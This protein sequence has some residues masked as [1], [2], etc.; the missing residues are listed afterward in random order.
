M[1]DQDAVAVARE[2]GTCFEVCPTSNYQSGVVA[3]LAQHPIQKMV[4]SGLNATINTDDPGI[5]QITLSGEYAQV[6]EGVGMGLEVL[7][8]GIIAAAQASFLPAEDRKKMAAALEQQLDKK[9]KP[10]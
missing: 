7:K 6:C 2:M 9:T 1:E 5:S 10:E 8:A 4:E 3:D